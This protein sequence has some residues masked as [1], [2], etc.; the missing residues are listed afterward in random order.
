MPT[1]RPSTS[2][3]PP[4]SASATSPGRTGEIRS[5]STPG[6]VPVF[7]ACGVTPQAVAL[8]SK[9]PFMITHS[10]GHMFIT[11]LAQRHAR[12][13]VSGPGR[14]ARPSFFPAGDRAVCVE[15]G[16]EISVEVNTRVRALELPDP[17]EG[18]GRA[19]S[20]RVPTFRSLLVYYDPLA[21]RLRDAGGEPSRRS[22]VAGRRAWRC[23]PRGTSSC[24]AATIPISAS[25][26]RRR[27]RRL[28]AVRG[29]G[30]AAA[31]GARPTT[32]TSSA[33]PRACP[34]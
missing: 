5:S 34:T 4:P 10:P 12:R 25:I 30:G 24:R 1:A 29:R 23:R 17:G 28:G 14:A 6:D 20:R 27:P 15:V 7:W 19:S 31:R 16:D 13:I 11:D 21:T 18:G 26:S 22:R 32:C 9:P 2:A 8:A 33:S 3:I